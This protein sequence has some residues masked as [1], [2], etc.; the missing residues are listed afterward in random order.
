MGA[1]KPRGRDNLTIVT[2]C[3]IF[4]TMV[5]VRP[6]CWW[7]CDCYIV[8]LTLC[9]ILRARYDHNKIAPCEMIKVFL[10]ELNTVGNQAVFTQ[11]L[12]YSM[13]TPR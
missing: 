13:A 7:W 12:W 5:K 4:I 10:I 9:I 2:V 1:G 11:V 8:L 6:F 3:S